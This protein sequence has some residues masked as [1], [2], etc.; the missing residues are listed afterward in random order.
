VVNTASTARTFSLIGNRAVGLRMGQT[1][2]AIPGI[3]PSG[4]AHIVWAP[5]R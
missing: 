5:W 3:L 1:F 2:G 4:C